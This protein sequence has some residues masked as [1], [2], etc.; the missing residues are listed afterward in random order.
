MTNKDIILT[1]DK[2]TRLYPRACDFDGRYNEVSY[3]NNKT[4]GYRSNAEEYFDIKSMT[5]GN[6]PAGSTLNATFSGYP[7][8]IFIKDGSDASIWCIKGKTVRD[9]DNYYSYGLVDGFYSVGPNPIIRIVE[10]GTSE[11]PDISWNPSI[12]ADYWLT[13][14]WQGSSSTVYGCSIKNGTLESD[15]SGKFPIGLSFYAG[16]AE[17][18]L[19]FKVDPN[20]RYCVTY[21]YSGVT[22]TSHPIYS[23][24]NLVITE[25]KSS[26]FSKDSFEGSG[27]RSSTVLGSSH[28]PMIFKPGPKT[29]YIQVGLYLAGTSETKLVNFEHNKTIIELREI[30]DYVKTPIN[31]LIDGDGN[32]LFKYGLSSKWLGRYL[33]EDTIDFDSKTIERYFYKPSLT[34]E[35]ARLDNIE[36]YSFDEVYIEGEEG[37]LEDNLKKYFCSEYNKKLGHYKVNYTGFEVADKLSYDPTSPDYSGYNSNYNANVLLVNSYT[38]DYQRLTNDI[39]KCYLQMDSLDK[40]LDKLG[41]TRVFNA[42][43][44][45]WEFITKE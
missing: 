29:N 31:K 32:H 6:I 2:S 16:D 3:Y 33:E 9:G 7:F 43:T 24:P 1:E 42:E 38:L 37:T 36:V 20:K 30:V 4:I 10:G 12:G 22:G 5:F 17:D 21:N 19:Y 13:S 44:N 25:F 15:A 40:V 23:Y 14:N 39:S 8:N 27:S 18:Q 34:A 45:K 41:I 28:R 11:T 26:D 35:P